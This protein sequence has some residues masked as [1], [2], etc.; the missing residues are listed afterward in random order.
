MEESRLLATQHCTDLGVE[1]GGIVAFDNSEQKFVGRCRG[2]TGVD[3]VTVDQLIAPDAGIGER[4][5]NRA[6]YTARI[7]LDDE[8][9]QC[10][11]R[12]FR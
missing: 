11:Q 5:G 12:Y 7:I 9:T 2:I 10:R 8:F 1:L 3:T 6:A 4:S